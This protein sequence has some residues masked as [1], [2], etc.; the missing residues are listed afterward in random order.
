M[1]TRGSSKLSD[2]VRHAMRMMAG[3]FASRILGLIREIITAA[4][5]GATRQLDA[6]YV[7]YTLAN[8]LRQLL[9]EGALSASFVPVFCGALTEGGKER[10]G[11]LARE[12]LTVL[13]I[14]GTAITVL[15]IFFAPLL[16]N[17]MAPGFP[18]A[19]RATAVSLT[20]I[21]FPFLLLVSVAALAMGVLNSLGCFFVPAI[22]PAVS[23]AAYILFL[24]AT[25]KNA[26]V[27]NLAAAVLLGGACQMLIQWYWSGRLGV[28]LIPALPR[29][30]NSELKTMMSLFLP[31]AAGLSLNQVNPVISRMFGSFLEDGSI[32]ALSYADRVLQLPLGIF[33]IAISQAV[34]P[35][36]SRLDPK[37]NGGFRDFIGDALRFNLFVVLPVA[38]GLFMLSDELVHLIFYRG[39]FNEWAWRAT[40]TALAIYGLGLP[41][42]ASGTVIMRA[43]YARK[44]PKAAVSITIV[45]VVVNLCACF[46]LTPR[47]TYAGL[48]AAS[49]L[50]FTCA[51]LYGGWTLSRDLKKPL[52]IFSAAWLGRI[53]F[54]CA[55]MTLSLVALKAFSPYPTAA[56]LSRRAL[57][58]ASALFAGAGTYGVTTI[59][60]KCPEWRWVRDALGR[61]GG[62]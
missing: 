25:M 24:L 12:A 10:A 30:D 20:R 60:L 21:M 47:F 36:L 33:V 54:S 46:A 44:M 19:A 16:V 11:R 52:N 29:K 62:E 18:A 15:G 31:Y 40:A 43:I 39:A 58:V 55:I 34:L 48:A 5:F 32:S 41:G 35:M 2:M 1:E 9:A 53:L 6:F 59:L 45:N 61:K 8:L 50:A 17:I 7:A 26:S 42:M 38:A 49:A 13:L 22:A 51:P 37:D 27:W 4:L 14:A 57:W 28:A 23:N 3:T 56:G